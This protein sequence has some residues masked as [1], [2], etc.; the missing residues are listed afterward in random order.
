MQTYV[1][2]WQYLAEFFFER[3]IFQTKVV[4]RIKGDIPPSI[5][6]SENC[7]VYEIMWKNMVQP[8][9]PQMTIKYGAR[10]LHAG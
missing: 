10:A 3:E 9:R 5:F 8:D 7:A 4:E 6:I 2:L 1:K